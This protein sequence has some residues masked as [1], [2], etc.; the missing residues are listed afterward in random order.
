MVMEAMR[1]SLLEH[2]AQQRR[3]QEEEA[4]RQR[5]EA[6]AGTVEGNAE[7]A[8]PSIPVEPPEPSRK[9]RHVASLRVVIYE[10]TNRRDKE[11]F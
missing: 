8:E 10:K 9:R 2:E 3:Q 7:A 5:E 4:K 11:C 1:L 6:A